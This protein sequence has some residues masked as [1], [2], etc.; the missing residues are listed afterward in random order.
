MTPYSAE[1]SRVLVN[2]AQHYEALVDAL[3]ARRALPYGM[4]WKASGGRR[5]LYELRDRTGNGSSRGPESPATQAEHQAYVAARD[6][7]DARIASGRQSVEQL[8]RV[9]RALRLPGIA[10]QAGLALLEFDLRR[11]TGASLLVVGTNAMLAYD[12]EA[13]GTIVVG[14]DMATD[15]FDLLWRRDH[16]VNLLATGAGSSILGALKAVDETYTINQERPFQVR[17]RQAYEVEVLVAPSQLAL[18]PTGERLQPVRMEEVEWLLG[19]TTVDQVVPAKGNGAARI[20]APDPRLYAL[21]KRWLSKKPT[22]SA[23]KKAKDGRQA[24]ALL[25]ACAGGVLARHPLSREFRDGLAAPLRGE[26]DDWC[27]ATGF[28]PRE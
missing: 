27:A 22:R 24:E 21:Q 1:Q 14:A 23:L 12:A 20:V 4:Q 3:R 11:M 16:P 10:E 7:A 2:L 9:A 13:G 5:Y 18:F 6:D 17:N 15:D 26:F 25:G 8:S 28:A 19:G